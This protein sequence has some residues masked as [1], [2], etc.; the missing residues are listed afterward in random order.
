[1]AGFVDDA[2]DADAADDGG[3][4]DD[5]NPYQQA[6]PTNA[7]AGDHAP[8]NVKQEQSLFSSLAPDSNS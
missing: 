8:S 6:K 1:M 5:D 2:A 3:G 7:G 4:G